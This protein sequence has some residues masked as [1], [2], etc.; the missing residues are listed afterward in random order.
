[1]KECDNISEVFT[2]LGGALRMTCSLAWGYNCFCC[3]F[4]GMEVFFTGAAGCL[5]TISFFF[6]GETSNGFGAAVLDIKL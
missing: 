4:A 2:S 3:C 5:A 6:P 1:L